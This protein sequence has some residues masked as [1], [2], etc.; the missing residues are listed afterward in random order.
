MRLKRLVDMSEAVGTASAV[1]LLAGAAPAP[2]APPTGALAPPPGNLLFLSARA[3]GTQTY[4]CLPAADRSSPASWRLLGPQARLSA[5][6]PD[7]HPDL[8][9]HVL[10]AVPGAATAP[11][12]ACVEAADGVQ[13]YCPSWRSPSDGSTVWGGKL[14]SAAAGSGPACPDRGSI[15]CL[16]LKAVA[17][18]SGPRPAGLFSRTTF[19]QRLDTS[20]GRAPAAACTVGQVALVPYAATYLFYARRP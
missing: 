7:A 2:A 10:A 1:L 3:K 9:E 6:E 5:S 16:L 18:S 4:V 15:A 14:A 11:Q 20:G 13:Q 8:A 12:P 17:T 19:I